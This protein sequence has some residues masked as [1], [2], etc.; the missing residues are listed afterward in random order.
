MTLNTVLYN[1]SN[2]TESGSH[3]HDEPRPPAWVEQFPALTG[4]SDPVWTEVARRAKQLVLPAGTDV[5]REGDGWKQF[6][7]V[8]DGVLRVYKSFESGRELVLYRVRTGETCCM[9]ATVM[10]G[11]GRYT[12]NGV[13]ETETRV[14]AIQARDFRE[15]FNH[16][17][18]FRTYV[19]TMLGR[20]FEDFVALLE[21]VTMR[22]VD[23]RLARWLISHSDDSVRVDV[24]HRELASELGTAREVISRH[25]KEFESRGW[26]GLGRKNIEIVDVP[27][28]H[29]FAY[30]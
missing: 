13:T 27:A 16:S 20:R 2:F 29:A 28:I 22:Q 11:G 8:T 6:L 23:V 9:T 26:V 12:A 7:F 25:L 24:S 3:P 18:G 21:S 10:F 1:Y 15:A 17:A 30:S 19:C 14:A 4:I 5:F